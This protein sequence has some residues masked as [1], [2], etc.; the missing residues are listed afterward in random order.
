LCDAY[1]ALPYG[2]EFIGYVKE[3]KPKNAEKTAKIVSYSLNN[4]DLVFID[5]NGKKYSFNEITDQMLK[6]LGGTE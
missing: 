4:K 3:Q 1:L 2:K 5:E 6:A